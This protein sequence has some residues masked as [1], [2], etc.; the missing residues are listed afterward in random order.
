MTKHRLPLAILGVLLVPAFAVAEEPVFDFVEV[1]F[2][3]DDPDASETFRTGNGWSLAGSYDLGKAH[4]F[5][6]YADFTTKTD[7]RFEFPDV[8][9]S[10]T[11]WNA[12]I[13]V[14]G[15]MGENSDVTVELAYN[16]FEIGAFGENDSDYAISGAVGIRWMFGRRIE[17]NASYGLLNFD[18]GNNQKYGSLGMIGQFKRYGVGFRMVQYEEDIQGTVFFRF[19]FKSKPEQASA[20]AAG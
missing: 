1:G 15:G 3:Y 18:L 11:R 14:H 6:A 4:L 19:H 17:V 5:G 16:D 2:V 8:D 13:G 10:W 9:V 7:D 12:G 20:E